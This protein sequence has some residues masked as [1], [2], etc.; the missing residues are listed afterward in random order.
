VPLYWIAIFPQARR[1]LRAWERRAA[2]IPD[3]ELRAHALAKLHTEGLTAEG[4]AAFAIVAQA[5]AC[6]HVVRLCVA[7]EV[8]YDYVDALA[9]QPVADVLANNRALYGAL[10]AALAPGAP[11]GDPY[12]HHPR[13]DDGGYLQALVET[14]RAALMRLPAAAPVL[15]ALRRCAARAGEAQS[16]HHA[17]AHGREAPL[18]CWAASIEPAGSGLAWWEL[19]AAAGSPLVFYALAAAAARPGTTEKDAVAVEQA[20][21][22]WIAALS[23][24]LESLV[25]QE[26][27][28][29][30]GE[31][32]YVGHYAS[33]GDAALRLTTIAERACADA[34][35]LPRASRHRLLLAGTAG[36]YLS[37]AGATCE[38]ARDGADAVRRTIGAP[39]GLL[40]STL[41]LRRRIA[42]L[43]LGRRSAAD[44]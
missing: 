11:T 17:A 33:P 40:L 6:R 1:E 43:R 36:M 29:G 32:S 23:W 26:D 4:A 37:H 42:R 18:A 34:A 3:P 13:D 10:G 28:R 22:P 9:E 8:I 21:F 27:D 41:R 15:P 7:L 31:H 24:L 12:R 38:D 35:R 14:C 5:P 25:D 44:A 39:L 30:S 16:L 20:Y 19:A 2:T